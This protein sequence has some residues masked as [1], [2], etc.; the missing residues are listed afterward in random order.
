MAE[1]AGAF[2][3]VETFVEGAVAAVKGIYDPTLPLKT[4]L[5]PVKDIDLPRYAH[6]VSLV[7]GRAYVFGGITSKDGTE[8]CSKPDFMSPTNSLPDIGRQRHAR[9]DTAHLRHRRV[10]L[11]TPPLK[12]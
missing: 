6:T 1:A 4:D 9:R 12:S 8:V 11:Q 2:Y 5:V 3:A 7:K 10:R